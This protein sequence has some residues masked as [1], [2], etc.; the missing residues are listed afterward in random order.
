MNGYALMWSGGKDSALALWRARQRGL[1]VEWLVNIHDRA[2]ARVRFHATGVEAIAR[3]AET[4]GVPLVSVRPLA[5]FD[6][7]LR[8]RSPRWCGS[9]P[10]LRLATSPRHVAAVTGA[11]PH[12][13]TGAIEPL[14]ATTAFALEE[15]ARS[16]G[17]R[18]Q[19]RR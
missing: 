2:T 13:G 7:S 6:E 3:Q 11:H 18:C 10:R 15:F 17:G 14:W 9:V 19:M 5:T 4:A 1:R 8:T 12:R 16:A